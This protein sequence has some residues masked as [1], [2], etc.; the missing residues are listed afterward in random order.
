MPLS[1]FFQIVSQNLFINS[2][3][4]SNGSKKNKQLIKQYNNPENL[5]NRIDGY[6]QKFFP[7]P[8]EKEELLYPSSVKNIG[9]ESN[10]GMF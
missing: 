5:M 10:A 2:Q 3:T 7:S 6:R 8:N 4:L 1:K 9:Q